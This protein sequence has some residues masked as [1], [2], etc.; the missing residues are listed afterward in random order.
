MRMPVTNNNIAFGHFL[1][2]QCMPM[3]YEW[4]PEKN[5]RL[6]SERGLS[7]EQVVFHLSQGDVWR[8]AE[9]PNQ[10]KYPGQQI[11]FVLMGGYIYLIP[12]EEKDGNIMLK[13]IIPSRK[14]TRDYKQDMED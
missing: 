9:N 5:E 14:A 8:I 11:Y 13:T 1:N 2:V 12:F 7:F 4:H 10:E 6:K 3:R